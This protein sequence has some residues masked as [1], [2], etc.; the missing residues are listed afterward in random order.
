MSINWVTNQIGFNIPS[1]TTSE[2]EDIR[3]TYEDLEK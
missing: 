3:I 1:G 2:V